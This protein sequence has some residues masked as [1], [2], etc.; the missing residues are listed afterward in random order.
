MEVQL[1]VG[2]AVIGNPLAAQSPVINVFVIGHFRERG[3]DV[4][5]AQRADAIDVQGL[6]GSPSIAELGLQF[7]PGLG[8]GPDVSG[9]A[10]DGPALD[11]CQHSLSR[12]HG[13]TCL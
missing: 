7:A 9:N 11:R 8:S 2:A 1:H 10:I 13:S 4:L 12:V 5:G 6:K 3:A